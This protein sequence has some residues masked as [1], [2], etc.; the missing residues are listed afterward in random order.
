MLA[1][2]VALLHVRLSKISRSELVIVR[3]EIPLE[4]PHASAPIEALAFF[5]SPED[6]P[7][8]HLR[9]QAHLAGRLGRRSLL[10]AWRKAADE[11]ELRATLRAT[12]FK[13][14]FE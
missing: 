14:A 9:V 11:D 13:A 7:A 5:V 2:G 4:V 1:P 10:P 6:H 12:K 8:Q 3:C